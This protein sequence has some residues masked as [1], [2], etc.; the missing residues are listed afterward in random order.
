MLWRFRELLA[1]Q[2]TELSKI[3][4]SAATYSVVV[5]VAINLLKDPVAQVREVACKVTHVPFL[6]LLCGVSHPTALPPV[7]WC[8]CAS[9]RRGRPGLAQA[10]GGQAAGVWQVFILPRAHH[11]GQILWLHGTRGV[12]ACLL[13][14]RTN[15][16]PHPLTHS[17]VPPQMEATIFKSCFL[18]SLLDLARDPCR[19]VRLAVA[20]LFSS[21]PNV[22]SPGMTN[23]TPPMVSN[24]AS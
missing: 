18:A 13:H 8:H 15:S 3:F 9:P 24:L 16:V 17:L 6:L 23:L 10:C 20:R 19:N 21:A 22:G 11:N 5:P 4:S 7:Y 12:C 14:T 1:S 2:L